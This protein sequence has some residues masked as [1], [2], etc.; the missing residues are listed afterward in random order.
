MKTH[1]QN[2]K[3]FKVLKVQVM[4]LIERDLYLNKLI[5]ILNSFLHAQDTKSTTSK[6]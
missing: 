2:L 6:E 3:I 4:K 1:F 5:T